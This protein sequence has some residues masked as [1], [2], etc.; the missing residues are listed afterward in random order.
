MNPPEGQWLTFNG[1]HPK[2]RA[3]GCVK[4]GGLGFRATANANDFDKFGLGMQRME[5]I[6][7]GCQR[8]GEVC[9]MEVV[10]G[11]GPTCTNFPSFQP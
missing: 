8:V 10:E 9:R 1:G 2:G 7:V 4:R 6:Q 3:L 11:E 5:A